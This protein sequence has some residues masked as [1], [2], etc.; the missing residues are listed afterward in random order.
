MLPPMGGPPGCAVTHE[1][2]T[3]SDG[4]LEGAADPGRAPRGAMAPGRSRHPYGDSLG[5]TAPGRTPGG[6]SQ[7]HPRVPP[8]KAA[9][10]GAIL[11]GGNSPG[12]PSRSSSTLG[13]LQK[14]VVPPGTIPGM[15]ALPRGLPEPTGA[16][17]EA[18]VTLGAPPRSA[19]LPR[20]LTGALPEATVHNE[21]SQCH[22]GPSVWMAISP[23]SSSAPMGPSGDGDAPRGDG[24]HR[25]PPREP[26][27]MGR[28]QGPQRFRAY[29]DRVALRGRASV[30]SQERWHFQGPYWGQQRPQGLTQRRQHI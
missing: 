6:P 8:R 27:R 23:G 4:A 12:G 9:L 28:P 14:P 10:P 1:G 30:H 29:K 2:T 19:T 25:V 5:T 11:K 16:L 7:G 22:Q 21:L 26:T 20:V 15:A 24:A 18:V 3:T 13:A 17:Q